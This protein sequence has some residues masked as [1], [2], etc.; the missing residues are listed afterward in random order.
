METANHSRKR[1]VRI[2]GVQLAKLMIRYD[3][4]LETIFRSE[5]L[6]GTFFD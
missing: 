5:K 4:G 1:I 3:A 6:T 2:D